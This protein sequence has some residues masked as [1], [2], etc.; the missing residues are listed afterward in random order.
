MAAP[1]NAITEREAIRNKVEPEDLSIGNRNFI[2]HSR[3][4]GRDG[5]ASVSSSSRN[6]GLDASFGTEGASRASSTMGLVPPTARG[7]VSDDRDNIELRDRHRSGSSPNTRVQESHRRDR[8]QGRGDEEN[9]S[10]NEDDD[11]DDGNAFSCMR[12]DC[13][14]ML[15]G[16]EFNLNVFARLP[17]IGGGLKLGL[18]DFVFYSVLVARAGN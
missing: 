4:T 15:P 2:G 3:A 13:A 12:H 8:D 5:G 6:S 16:F 7:D 17:R 1:P 10:S 18:G 9:N 11:D 14:Q